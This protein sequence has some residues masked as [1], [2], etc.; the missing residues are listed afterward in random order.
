MKKLLFISILILTF[1]NLSAQCV[2]DGYDRVFLAGIQAGTTEKGEFVTSLELS[3]FKARPSFFVSFVGE[4]YD[5]K[6]PEYTSTT[7]HV[8]LRLN[9]KFLANSESY[10]IIVFTGGKYATQGNE[11]VD[12]YNGWIFEG[13]TAFMRKLG[14][15]VNSDAWLRA[16]V[17]YNSVPGNMFTFTL[18]MQVHF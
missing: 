2:R 13:G 3:T 18:G 11:K 9:K 7:A 17:T 4:F 1:A 6:R 12:S 15:T 8:G 10:R 16:N 5:A 14:E